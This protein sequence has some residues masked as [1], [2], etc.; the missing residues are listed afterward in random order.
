[1]YIHIK[2]LIKMYL[3][4][5]AITTL[6]VIL[7]AGPCIYIFFHYTIIFSRREVHILRPNVVSDLSQ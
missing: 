1:M 5:M 4:Y 6:A 7:R 2:E 3:K